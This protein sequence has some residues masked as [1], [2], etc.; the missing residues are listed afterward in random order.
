MRPHLER[1]EPH[2]PKG[3][4][5]WRHCAVCGNRGGDD[6]TTAL[7][8][9]NYAIPP[10]ERAYAHRVCMERAYVAAEG[11]LRRAPRA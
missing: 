11:I 3:Q 9:A 8:V 10:E 5:F 2:P 6:C 7:I 4:R 1:I